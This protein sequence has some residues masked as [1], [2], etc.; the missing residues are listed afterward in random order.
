MLGYRYLGL[1]WDSKNRRGLEWLKS[2]GDFSPLISFD[3][4]A[5]KVVLTGVS[6]LFM[7][8]VIG[9]PARLIYANH[10]RRPYVNR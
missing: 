2:R 4:V 10:M 9:Y 8:H 6:G 5:L 7:Y 1:V 3:F